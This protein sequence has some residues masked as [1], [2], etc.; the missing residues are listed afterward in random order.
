MDRLEKIESE[1]EALS[2]EEL[3][4]FRAWFDEYD[5]SKWDD[6]LERDV[7]AGKLD[8]LAS[9]ALNEHASGETKAL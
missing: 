7:E 5:W 4:S 9:D 3:A 1:V 2:D 8:Q 6:Q